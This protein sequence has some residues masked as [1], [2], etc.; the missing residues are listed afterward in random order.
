MIVIQNSYRPGR[1]YLMAFS[2]DMMPRF[3]FIMIHLQKKCIELKLLLIEMN[4]IR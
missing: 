2:L 4:F 1:G 3:L